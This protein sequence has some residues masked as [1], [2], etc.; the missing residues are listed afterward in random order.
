MLHYTRT[1][2]TR[3]VLAK[4]INSDSATN[5]INNLIDLMPMYAYFA[6]A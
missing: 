3:Y 5:V 2:D 1:N 6:R 4:C